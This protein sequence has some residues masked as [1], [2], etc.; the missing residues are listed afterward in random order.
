MAD[1]AVT[2]GIDIGGTNTKYGLVNEGGKIISKGTLATNGKQGASKFFANLC[3]IIKNEFKS[4]LERKKIVAIGVGAPNANYYSGKIENPPN[5]PWNVVDVVSEIRH[6]IDVPVFVTN[7][8]NATAIGEM[9]YGAAKGLKDFIV[10]TLGTGLGSGIVI[11]G[12]LVYGADGFA[13]EL[14][15]TCV[16]ANGRMCGCGKKGCLETYVSA[17]G[18]R[19]TVFQLLARM[20]DPSPLRGITYNKLTAKRIAELAKMGDAIA[21]EAFEYTGRLLGISLA[22]A[23]AFSRPEAIILFGGLTEAGTILFKPTKKWFEA[24]LLDIYK[25]K[26]KILKSGLKES[27]SAILGAGALAWDE[28]KKSRR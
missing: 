22:N 25:D 14:G 27:N 26:I 7:D 21:K 23:A 15:H 28:L 9:Y 11:N 8:A 1:K 10:I 17:T 16:D 20:N 5:L 24:Y 6:C 4:T 19:R 18:I 3:D 13:G 2:L 12:D